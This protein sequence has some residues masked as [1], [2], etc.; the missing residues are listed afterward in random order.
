MNPVVWMKLNSAIRK[1]GLTQCCVG[2]FKH[3]RRWHDIRGVR[4]DF[5]DHIAGERQSYT[6]V[7]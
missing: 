3:L 4:F 5:I 6:F 1:A 7:M 2:N